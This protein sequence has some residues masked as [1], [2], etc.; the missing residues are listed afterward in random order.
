MKAVLSLVIFIYLV[1]GFQESDKE[2]RQS[3]AKRTSKQD[4]PHL[5]II[6]NKAS[7]PNDLADVEPHQ[8]L[9]GNESVPQS[10]L[11]QINK[12]DERH[13]INI[14]G[15]TNNQVCQTI[16]K[17][18]IKPHFLIMKCIF[19]S[20]NEQTQADKSL[21]KLLFIRKSTMLELQ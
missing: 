18:T 9:C 13:Y 1:P 16:I 21:N 17:C 10:I 14:L 5:Y 19:S 8:N 11:G 7:L 2:N 6:A 3:S 15:T 20:I 12:S 4:S